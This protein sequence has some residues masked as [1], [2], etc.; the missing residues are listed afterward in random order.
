MTGQLNVTAT[1]ANFTHQDLVVDAVIKKRKV[2]VGLVQFGQTRARSVSPDRIDLAGH[3]RVKRHRIDI[4]ATLDDAIDIQILGI[5]D[6]RIAQQIDLAGCRSQFVQGRLGVV[7]VDTVA[8]T[9]ELSVGVAINAVG[10]QAVDE[11]AATGDRGLAGGADAGAINDIALLIERRKIAAVVGHVAFDEDRRID[12]VNA[13]DQVGIKRVAQRDR[14]QNRFATGIAGRCRQGHE[15]R[16]AAGNIQIVEFKV[17]PGTH[18]VEEQSA[19]GL[20]DRDAQDVQ[21]RR[22]MVDHCDRCVTRCVD[23]PVANQSVGTNVNDACLCPDRIDVDGHHFDFV[24]RQRSVA[25]AL[26]ET[27]GKQFTFDSRDFFLIEVPQSSV[28]GAIELQI[29]Y[30]GIELLHQT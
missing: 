2:L 16:R 17:C 14:W 20:G 5:D 30:C 9:L 24:G 7:G 28:R 19:V 25:L 1:D 6:H 26:S 27:L 22:G 15:V 8:Q 4:F 18:T 11:D 10:G 3:R 23:D 29:G 21:L 13:D 12:V